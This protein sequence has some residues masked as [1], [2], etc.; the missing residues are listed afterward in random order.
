ME[1]SLSD[2]PRCKTVQIA[3]DSPILCLCYGPYDNGPVI[4]A[5]AKGVVRVWE[6][7]LETGLRFTQQIDLLCLMGP[8]GIAVAVEQPFG[9]YVAVG[10]RRLYVWHRH[11]EATIVVSE[12]P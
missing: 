6:M 11:Q 7:M 1:W 2:K 12:R 4:T 10:G 3:H 5:D 9:L 8:A